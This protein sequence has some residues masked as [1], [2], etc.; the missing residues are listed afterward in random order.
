MAADFVSPGSAVRCNACGHT[1]A[2]DAIVLEDER[3]CCLGCVAG[4]ACVCAAGAFDDT[5]ATAPAP[6]ATPLLTLE[7]GPFS[8]QADLMRLAAFLEGR[9]GIVSV[10]LEVADPL[11][12]RFALRA[13]SVE[14]VAQAVAAIPDYE[15]SVT[16]SGDTVRAMI[17]PWRAAA[18]DEALLPPHPRFRVFHNAPEHAPKTDPEPAS[19]RDAL[20][21]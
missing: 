4:G 15:A 9:P 13:A 18:A 5:P 7:I 3:Y 8:S 2:R 1:I 21:S 20:H 10:A 12:A 11:R 19:H 6:R 16:V 17:A 14:R